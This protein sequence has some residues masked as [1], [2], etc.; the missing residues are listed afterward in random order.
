MRRRW[1]QRETIYAHVYPKAAPPGRGKRWPL[2]FGFKGAYQNEIE[3][4][5]LSIG[6]GCTS[7]WLSYTPKDARSVTDVRVTRCR[8]NP[9]RAASFIIKH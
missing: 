3:N 7:Y 5:M 1:P 6:Y 2:I 4:F 9:H 8:K